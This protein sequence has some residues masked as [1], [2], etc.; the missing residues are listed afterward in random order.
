MQGLAMMDGTQTGGLPIAV[1]I[2]L[3]LQHS[4]IVKVYYSKT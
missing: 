3:A 4:A 1:M 2:M